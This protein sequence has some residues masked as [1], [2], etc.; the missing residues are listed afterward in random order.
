LQEKLESR[1]K[2]LEKLTDDDKN[3]V[4]MILEFTLD[5]AA[6]LQNGEEEKI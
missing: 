4:K 6:K 1:L 2:R 3:T 5:K